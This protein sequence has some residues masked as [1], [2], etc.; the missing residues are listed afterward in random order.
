ML[1]FIFGAG[2]FTLGIETGQDAHSLGFFNSLAVGATSAWGIL[3]ALFGS[4]RN[5]WRRG[6]SMRI[7]K[8]PEGEPIARSGHGNRARRHVML[9]STL[10]RMPPLAS[11]CSILRAAESSSPCSIIRGEG[12]WRRCP[13]C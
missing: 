4:D 6:T 12:S 3:Q 2:A 7:A 10:E 5:K 9:A 11:S 13:L 8:L 1:G